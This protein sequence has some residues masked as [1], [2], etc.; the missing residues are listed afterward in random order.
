MFRL[1]RAELKSHSC[2][3]SA[4]GYEFC[5]DLFERCDK[6][7]DGA[8]SPDELDDLFSTCYPATWPP[9]WGKN[10]PRN[11]VHT[12]ENDYITLEGWLSI[13]RYSFISFC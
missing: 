11:V 10:F 5:S 7:K 12:N 2:E 13:W 9:E 6:D 4:A 8:L 1:E 3:L